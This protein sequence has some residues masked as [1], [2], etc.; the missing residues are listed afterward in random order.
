LIDQGLVVS[1]GQ[2][3]EVFQAIRDLGVMLDIACT[4]VFR[5]GFSWHAVPD[6]CQVQVCR[7]VQWS[8]HD[9]I[10]R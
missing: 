3:L 9:G 5:H 4:A 7:V 2:W 8:A 10:L 6:A 1:Q